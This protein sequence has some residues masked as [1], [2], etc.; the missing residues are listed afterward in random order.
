MN[1]FFIETLWI[2]L[3]IFCAVL[4]ALRTVYVKKAVSVPADIIIFTNRLMGF[5]ILL[6]LA[7]FEKPHITDLRRFAIFTAI[8]IAANAAASLTQVRV[9]Q[10]EDISASQPLLGLIPMFM[11]PWNVLLLG[12]NTHA[13]TLA[14][15]LI[16]CA[17]AYVMNISPGG[18]FLSPMKEAFVKPASRAML[19]SAILYGLTSVCDKPAIEA[20]SGYSYTLIWMFCSGTFVG[21]FFVSRRSGRE[22]VKAA[23]NRDNLI[24]TVFWASAFLAQMYAIQLAIHIE[25]SATYV[26]TLTL[27]SIIIT[28]FLGRLVF[29]EGNLK[30]NLAGATLILAGSAIIVMYAK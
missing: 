8:T 15:I 10:K 25:S 11:I 20:S 16:A 27:L 17:G 18:G 24:Q 30:R 29:R 12:E 9:I 14:G 7:V 4:I 28:V 3:S 6:P 5:L 23:L 1:E 26:K 13:V 22:I 2:Q 19:I 21:T